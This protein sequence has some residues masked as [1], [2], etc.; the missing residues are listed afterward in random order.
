MQ[1][2]LY[3]IMAHLSKLDMVHYRNLDGLGM[4]GMAKMNLI[5]GRNGTGKTSLLEAI[6]LF[7]GRDNPALLWDSN[8]QRSFGPN[9]NPLEG[10]ATDA[11]KITGTEGK[12]KYRYKA[13]FEPLNILDFT[14]QQE[15]GDHDVRESVTG[16]LHIKINGK[17]MKNK[18]LLRTRK[19]M[20]S[21]PSY[22]RSDIRGVFVSDTIDDNTIGRFSRIVAKGYKN[23]F[24]KTMQKFLPITDIDIVVSKNETPRIWITTDKIQQNAESFGGSITRL[25]NYN[26]ML[27]SAENGI[28][29][30]DGIENSIHYS[31]LSN[32]WK[33]VKST[34]ESLNA[35]IFATTHS[36]EW[37]R[38]AAAAYQDRPQDIMVY[39]L[40][41]D[42]EDNIKANKYPYDILETALDINMEI[43]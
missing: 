23:Q 7:H 12:E 5:V 24:I 18:E 17:E 28:A 31:V 26:T 37:I 41:H 14:T 32:F 11:V 38:A 40:Y 6:C 1:N 8:V 25:F 42:Q 30:I 39:A 33:G 34:S 27:Y 15:S 10:L 13:H 2:T 3:A 20:V 43:R 35:Q 22:S 16:R 19:G 9:Q 4:D 21:V 29:C 36:Y